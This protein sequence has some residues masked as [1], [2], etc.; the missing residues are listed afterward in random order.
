MSTSSMPAQALEI[1]RGL[2]DSGIT[3]FMDRKPEEVLAEAKRAATALMGV[4]NAKPKEDKVIMN[5]RLYLEFEDW[6]TVARFYGVQPKIESTTFVNFGDAQGFEAVAIATKVIDGKATEIGRADSMCLDDED[7]WGDRPKYE[8]QDDLDKDGKVQWV[9]GGPGGKNR[10]KRKKVLVGTEPTPLFQLRSM[11]QTRAMAKVLRSL[12][13]WVVVLADI[14]ISTTPLEE[15]KTVDGATIMHGEA[16][17]TA[18]A[19]Q[20]KQGAVISEPQMKR[21]FA[22]ARES[23][24]PDKNERVHKVIA[25]YGYEHAKD[26]L[27]TDYDQ[28]SKDIMD[29]NWKP[30]RQP[31]QQPAQAT[32]P[33]PQKVEAVFVSADAKKDEHGDY[34]IVCG[35]GGLFFYTRDDAHID[36]LKGVAPGKKVAFMGKP[37]P[38]RGTGHFEIIAVLKNGEREWEA[39]GTPVIQQNADVQGAFGASPFKG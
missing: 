28:I 8:W 5:G 34:L 16:H 25:D 2:Q 39:D 3:V 27:K 30:K 7:N 10:P 23:G 32:A 37:L 9:E 17:A 20:K 19:A 22:I 36:K 1:V 18:P 6:A 11:A 38:M 35:E 21:L 15:V 13:S 33:Q 4:I 26:V 14:P 31:G 12:F 24:A 29:P